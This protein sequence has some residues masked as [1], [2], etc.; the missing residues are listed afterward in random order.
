MYSVR[1][2]WHIYYILRVPLKTRHFHFVQ[3]LDIKPRP[4]Y[5]DR[6]KHYTSKISVP[7]FKLGA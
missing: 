5:I 6:P 3:I 4:F 7:Y 1:S 2:S